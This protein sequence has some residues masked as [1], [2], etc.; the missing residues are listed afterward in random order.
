[1]LSGLKRRAEKSGVETDLI[2][3]KLAYLTLIGAFGALM[4][5]LPVFY[6]QQEVFF[7]SILALRRPTSYLLLCKV[8]FA[9]NW[10]PRRYS[11]VYFLSNIT[12]M[13]YYSG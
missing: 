9:S 13:G 7:Y 6:K 5:F 1:M 4:P 11:A 10:D 3:P 2:L 12:H 8:S